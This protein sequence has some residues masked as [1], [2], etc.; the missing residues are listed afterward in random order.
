MAEHILLRHRQIPD[1][2]QLSVY[3]ANR[4]YEAF[5]K[6]VTT[7]QPDEVIELVKASG[8]RG[9]GGAGFPTGMK[10]SFTDKKAWP[11]YVVVNADE[12][13][14][15]TFKDR[16][17]ME[18]NPFQFLEGV[19]IAAYAV[20]A[21]LAYIYLRGEFWQIAGALEQKIAELEAAGFLGDK[22]FGTDY[23][24]RMHTHLG[25]GAYICG[26]ETALLESLE[27][28]LGQPRLRPPFPPSFGLYGKPTVVNN[29]ETLTNVPLIVD[30]GVEWFRGFGTEKSPGTK[31]FCLSGRV[32]RPGNY[33][34]PLGT[35][36]RELI[37]EHGGGI[38]DGRKIK[39]IMPAGA[40]S[41]LIVANEQA[42]DTKMDYESVPSVGAQL[43]SASL[44]IIDETVSIDWLI[45]KTVHFF[46]HESCGKCTPCREGT[47]WME[48]LTHR[49]AHGEAVAADVQLLKDVASQIKGKCLCALGEFSIEAVLSG[50]DRFREDFESNVSGGTVEEPTGLPVGVDTLSTNA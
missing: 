8:L 44:I 4:G 2:D 6:V 41:S 36:F 13:E 35:T 24:L 25:A 50:L 16:E 12:S 28:K 3:Q 20:G 21:Q 30:R 26:E 32:N 15:G 37:Y 10:W 19:A 38:I 48:K 47:Y 7:M 34:L 31:I 9:R 49:I 40:S 1:L 33:E 22:I 5:R 14:P 46:K 17:I 42:L 29:V 23:A 45:S 27:G 18:S 39:A 11:H 43:G